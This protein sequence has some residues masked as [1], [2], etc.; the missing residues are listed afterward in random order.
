M[1]TE[2]DA[3]QG[4]PQEA[5]ASVETPSE[6]TTEQ[7]APTE[8][9]AQPDAGEGSEERVKREP[10]F[11][12]RINEVTRDK[13]AA[14]REAEALRAEIAQ[15]RAPPAEAPKGP[16]TLE[17]HGWDDAAHARATAE[18]Y[19]EQAKATVREELAAERAQAAE[20]TRMQTVHGKLAEASA[21][22][23]DFAEVSQMI[24]TNDAVMELLTNVPNAVDVLYE[25]GKNPVEADRIFSLSPYL[26]AAEL[27]K[28]AARLEAPRATNRTIAP[29]PPQTVGGLSAGM[30]LKSPNEM[31]M[32]EYADARKKGLI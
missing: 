9:D 22:Y 21:K 32:A 2:T 8:T 6:A 19:R 24:P 1:N 20:A 28:I 18:Y 10:W 26:Q 7:Q 29:P 5:P 13:Y 31:S 14:Q 11:Q 3:P 4:E 27:G 25:V 12:K 30:T 16:P 15:M 23:S 17:E